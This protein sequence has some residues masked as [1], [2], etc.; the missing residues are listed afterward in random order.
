MP[1]TRSKTKRPRGAL[2][3]LV[4]GF[5]FNMC[6]VRGSLGV[7]ETPRLLNLNSYP[8]SGDSGWRVVY[9]G[10]MPPKE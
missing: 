8:D 6:S 9:L 10:R 1:A 2:L 5:E 3:Q 4:I 7:N